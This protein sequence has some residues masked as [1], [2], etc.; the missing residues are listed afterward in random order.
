M[1]EQQQKEAYAAMITYKLMK[2]PVA[3]T[4]LFI[5]TIGSIVLAFGLLVW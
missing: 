3:D 1:P 4:E 5:A 2:K